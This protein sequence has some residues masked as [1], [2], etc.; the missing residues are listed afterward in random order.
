[1]YRLIKTGSR[2]NAENTLKEN[3][4]ESNVHLKLKESD[5]KV[6]ETNADNH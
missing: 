3:Q 2:M 5:W 6:K 1:M 4:K